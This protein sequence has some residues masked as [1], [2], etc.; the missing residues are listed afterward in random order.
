MH[1]LSTAYLQLM[2]Y[3]ADA[4]QFSNPKNQE[5]IRTN[6]NEM[7][8]ASAEIAKEPLPANSD[9][10]ISYT[11]NRFAIEM[12]QAYTAYELKDL[13]WARYSLS[14]ASDY[15][16][17][18]HTSVNH[19]SKDMPISWQLQLANL[20]PGEKIEALLANR[21]Y[22]SA[23]NLS[24]SYVWNKEAVQT[25]ARFYQL[26]LE[27]VMAMLIRVNDNKAEAQQLA[28]EAL[29]NTAAPFY[30]RNDAAA[31]FEDIKEWKK[32][33]P[34]TSDHAKLILAK[35]LVKKSSERPHM[36]ANLVPSLRASALLHGL[37]T[38]TKGANRA[39]VLYQAGLVAQS[40]RDINLGY[41][42]QYYFEGCIR[43][44]PHTNL[45]EDCFVELDTSVRDTGLFVELEPDS[46]YAMETRL[47]DLR[48]LAEV[49]DAEGPPGWKARIW[50][51]DLDENGR[52]IEK[53][54]G[55]H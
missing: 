45:A 18:C 30:I 14:H 12:R 28:S 41:L 22:A 26:T 1:R 24:H 17:N 8:Q 9:P 37:L 16:I 44:A 7:R 53:K 20:A 50:N 23:L 13:P 42:D 4:K 15:C 6:L 47:A 36:S 2:P 51:Y 33:K 52:P 21:Q 40:L 5:T 43:Q 48:Q 32:E 54:Q 49:R 25:R 19:G 38:T 31:W 34:A 35:S 10:V 11:S 3:V 55:E 46:S 27:R 29:N 39:E